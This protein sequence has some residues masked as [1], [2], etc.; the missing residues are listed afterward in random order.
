MRAE[1]QRIDTALSLL[2]QDESKIVKLYY[3]ENYTWV[4]ISLQIH[5]SSKQCQRVRDRDIQKM[6]TY[7]FEDIY[8][9][10]QK[11]L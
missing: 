6:Y 10:I 11:I 7:L 2:S 3:I 5:M 9:E 4:N 8:T 1:K